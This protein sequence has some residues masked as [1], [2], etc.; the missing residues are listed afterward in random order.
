MKRALYLV[1]TS[2]AA[3]LLLFTT[4]SI[5]LPLL[6]KKI[7]GG[8][9]IGDVVI[10]IAVLSYGLF[11]YIFGLWLIRVSCKNRR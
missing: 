6:R 9:T 4:G 1:L 11:I 8:F 7:I 3:L 10:I 5:M 2:Y